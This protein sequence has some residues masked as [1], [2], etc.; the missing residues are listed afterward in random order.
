MAAIL[1]RVDYLSR[2]RRRYSE[3]AR[4]LADRQHSHRSRTPLIERLGFLRSLTSNSNLNA[5]NSDGPPAPNFVGLRPVSTSPELVDLTNESDSSEGGSREGERNR[6]IPAGGVNPSPGQSPRI[7]TGAN[8]A[9]VQNPS[10]PVR[11]N[12]APGN[13]FRVLED[14][15]AQG[16]RRRVAREHFQSMFRYIKIS[17]ILKSRTFLTK[18]T[19]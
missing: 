8:P 3:R 2:L 6:R 12:P 13:L 9:P 16:E 10:N 19:F 11:V 18:V 17:N 7:P 14:E 15:Q 4:A 1:S 5:S